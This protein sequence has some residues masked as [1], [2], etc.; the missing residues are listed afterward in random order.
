MEASSDKLT[1][2]R[3]R[4]RAHFEG[5]IAEHKDRWS[6]LWD[7]PVFLPFDRYVSS[8]YYSL[9]H[10]HLYS[11]QKDIPPKGCR[12]HFEWLKIE[13]FSMVNIADSGS[14]NRYVPTSR[15][16]FLKQCPGATC[17]V[18]NFPLKATYHMERGLRDFP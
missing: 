18:L 17:P 10:Q 15:E 6:Q 8:Q 14:V 5:D 7:N 13:P 2:A 16:V 3:A 1:D 4:L 12:S 9:L 11:G